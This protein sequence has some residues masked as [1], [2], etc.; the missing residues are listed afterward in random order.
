MN[1][2]VFIPGSNSM[3]PSDNL[4]ERFPAIRL[5]YVMLITG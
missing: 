1:Y 4:P 3:L 2:N 5:E